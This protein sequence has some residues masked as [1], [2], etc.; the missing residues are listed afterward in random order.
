[1]FAV[2]SQLADA[3]HRRSLRLE[4]LERQPAVKTNHAPIVFVHGAFAGAWCWGEHFLDHFAKHGHP[5]YALS[6]R[7]HGESE[8]RD[9]LL[10]TSLADYADDVGSVLAQLGPRVILVG[11][12]MGGMVVQKC[13]ERQ[14]AA[15]AILMASVPPRGL[16]GPNL[17]MILRDPALWIGLGVAQVGGST[18]GSLHMVR[19]ALF[20]TAVSDRTVERVVGQSQMESQRVVFDLSGWDLPDVERVRQTPILVLGAA[21][22]ALVAE[23]HVRATAKAYA[24]KCE[25]FPNMAHAMMLELTWERVAHSM[26]AWIKEQ[27]L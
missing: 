8:G 24:A 17:A 25:V 15:A 5:A 7:G 23:E 13:L 16:V 6:L 26:L 1:M 21:D 20:A 12:S 27:A 9:A 3:L 19:R 14:P 22:D 2:A 4:V 18:F 11:H 10:W